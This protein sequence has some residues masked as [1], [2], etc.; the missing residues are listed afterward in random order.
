VAVFI[1]CELPLYLQTCSVFIL[2]A[3]Y[4]A[5]VSKVASINMAWFAYLDGPI[6]IHPHL[7][8]AANS[9]IKLKIK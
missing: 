7:Q 9:E 5:M 2:T 3:I 4:L 6:P 8:T 1:A